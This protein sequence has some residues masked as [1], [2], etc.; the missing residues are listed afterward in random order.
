MT[1]NNLNVK[2][3]N[4]KQL[5]SDIRRVKI[6]LVGD[7]CLDAYWFIDESMSEISVET[8]L[9]TRPVKNQKY[10]IKPGFLAIPHPYK[11][12]SVQARAFD[13]GIPFTGHPMIGH[14]IIYN[15]SMNHGAAIGRTTLND[16][17][18]ALYQYLNPH[19]T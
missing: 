18:L 7:F 19:T 13:L 8:G 10:N 6:A 9:A 5:L 3:E 1:V 4:L 11:K 12:F 17:L 2:K 14:D 15:H 16:F